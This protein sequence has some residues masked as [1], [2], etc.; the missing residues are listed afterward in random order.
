MI[1]PGIVSLSAQMQDTPLELKE[2]KSLEIPLLS[3][4]TYS[5]LKEQFE[6]LGTLDAGSEASVFKVRS[7][8]NGEIYALRLDHS[9]RILNLDSKQKFYKHMIKSQNQIPH[10]AKIFAVFWTENKNYPIYGAKKKRVFP[11]SNFPKGEYMRTD[12]SSDPE[13]IS[14]KHEVIIMELGED[15]AE[16]TMKGVDPVIFHIQ[17]SFNNYCLNQTGI[18]S[19]DDKFRNYVW[20]SIANQGYNNKLLKDFSYWHYSVGEH[21]FYIPRQ[22]YIPKRVDFGGWKTKNNC[23]EKVNCSEML[24]RSVTMDME[25]LHKCYPKPNVP[26]NEILD[27]NSL[28]QI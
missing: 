20:I 10:L 21:N 8:K 15:N 12:F 6:N 17:A 5:E 18:L 16:K 26:E 2:K 23:E 3:Q 13:A 14:Y 25:E 28:L 7:K 24:A 1:T 9:T 11:F 22:D 27:M 4:L 19:I